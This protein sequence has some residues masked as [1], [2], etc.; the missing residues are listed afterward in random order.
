MEEIWRMRPGDTSKHQFWLIRLLRIFSLA[1]RRFFTD[2]GDIKASALTFY[3]LLSVVPLAAISFGVAKGFGFRD[4]LEQELEKRLMGHEEVVQYVQKFAIEYL[5]NTKGGMLAAIGVGVLLVAVM[6]LLRNI[7]ASFNDIWDVKRARPFIRQFSDYVSL[8]F[9]AI[10]LLIT[11]GSLVVTI[12][13][14]IRDIGLGGFA[15]SLVVW[16]AP[17]FMM[18]LVFSLLF[19]IMPNT[20]VKP[21]AAIFGG[22]IAGTLFLGLQYGYIYFQVGVSRYNAIYGSF[23]ALPLFLIWNQLSWIIVLFGAELSFAY[24]NERSFE[25]DVD[26]RNMSVYA[27]KLVSLLIVREVNHAF[28]KGAK[29]L[30]VAQIAENLKLPIRLTTDLVYKM[31]GADILVEVNTDSK[32]DTVILPAFD[33]NKMDIA[34]II[35]KLEH[36]GYSETILDQ[37]RSVELVREK[38]DYYE[39]VVAKLPENKLL[40]DF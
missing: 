16:V 26:T 22:I 35:K 30:S 3:T 6:K 5:D 24:Q 39:E 38:I 9:V 8:L 17:Y 11:S 14:S 20:K 31:M 36:A 25:F 37:S 15:S 28:D 12:S 29:P 10:V 32:E 18:W 21:G 1:V 19:M 40:K 4:A 2:Q 13:N 34:G 7:E 33:I 27:Q 23:A